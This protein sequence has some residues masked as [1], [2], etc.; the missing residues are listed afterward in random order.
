MSSYPEE[1]PSAASLKADD[2]VSDHAVS[3][4]EGKRA[5]GEVSAHDDEEFPPEEHQFTW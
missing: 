4:T 3:F 1:K 5:D 2:T